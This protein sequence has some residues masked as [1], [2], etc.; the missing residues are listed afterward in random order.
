LPSL[1][2]DFEW[3]HIA[4]RAHGYSSDG[5]DVGSSDVSW[6]LGGGGWISTIDDFMRYG[7]ALMGEQVNIS[8]F[9]L[10]GLDLLRYVR[11]IHGR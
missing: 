7:S 2:P 4:H 3:K 6:K 5:V 11:S 8:S 10:I 9:L 1:Q